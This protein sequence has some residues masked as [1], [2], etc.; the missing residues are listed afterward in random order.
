MYGGKA[1]E[2]ALNEQLKQKFVDQLVEHK[3]NI[4]GYPKFDLTSSEG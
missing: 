4:V 1:Y 3:L 2:D